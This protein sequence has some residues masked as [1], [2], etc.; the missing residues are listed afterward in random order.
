MKSDTIECLYLEISNEK[1][2]NIILSLNY[3]PPNSDT[4]L[5]RKL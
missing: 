4:K 5:L 3:R 2:K 1:S